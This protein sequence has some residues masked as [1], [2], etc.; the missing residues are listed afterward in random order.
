MTYIYKPKG[1]ALEYSPLALNI[2]NS[3]DHGCTYCYNRHRRPTDHAIPRKLDLGKLD[4]EM[5]I[6][7]YDEQILLS[8]IGDPYCHAEMQYKL[9]RDVLEVMQP[10]DPKVAILTKGGMRAIRDIDLFK[11]FGDRIKVG[12]TLTLLEDAR[13]AEYEPNSAP[14]SE[15]LAMLEMLY[16]EGI[17][18]WASIEPVMDPDQAL[19]VM[20]AALPFLNEIRVGKLNHDPKREKEIDWVDFG[21]RAR[22]LLWPADSKTIVYFKIDLR[23]QL[24]G[25]VDLPS[26]WDDMSR[27]WL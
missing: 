4:D 1:R 22:D 14:P 25:K 16:D 20:E 23:D 27:G 12:A 26:A 7:N 11:Q 2:Y 24:A 18:T 17:R 10:Y 3:C 5:E 21:R 19:K 9:T 13:A 6:H 8:F 15:R